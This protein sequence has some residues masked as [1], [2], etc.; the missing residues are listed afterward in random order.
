MGRQ[1]RYTTQ[2]VIEA[3]RGSNGIV[4]NV[5]MRL[6]CE[7]RTVRRYID[8]YPTVNRAYRDEHEKMLDDVESKA[9]ELARAG[10]GPMI[11]YLLSTQGRERGYVTRQEVAGV[12]EQPL[13]VRF[14]YDD[15][16]RDIARLVGLDVAGGE[17]GE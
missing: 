8:K 4:K 5:A 9:L 3:I 11:R 16:A 12:V 13:R 1:E 15:V 6:G 17:D 10:D 14:T 2:Q 7:W